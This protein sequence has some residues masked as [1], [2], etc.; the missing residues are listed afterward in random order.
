[1]A[2][3]MSD[4]LV[5]TDWLAGRLADPTVRVVDATWYLAGAGRTGAQDHAERRIP[6]AVFWDLDAIADRT[7]ELPTMLPNADEMAEHMQRLGI[8]PDTQVVVY[9]GAGVVSAPRVWWLLRHYGHARVAVLDGGLGKWVAEGRPVES[10]APVPAP[11]AQPFVARPRR[12]LVWDLNAVRANIE[13]RTVQHVDARSQARFTGAEKETRPGSRSG[14][15]PGSLNL[16]FNELMDPATKTMLAPER[17]AARFAQAGID[18]SRPIMCSC[19]SG[20]TAAVL[21]LGL[22]LIGR[23]DTPIY[24]GSWS[25]WGTR[26]DTPVAP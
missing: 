22:N 3:P 26:S 18:V 25:E 4:A 13:A 14:H 23:P 16:P 1:M 15:V 8:G 2:Y 5:T 24:D 17:I 9:N 20:V 11:R 21:A 6:G 19:G 12:E 10:G 7:T